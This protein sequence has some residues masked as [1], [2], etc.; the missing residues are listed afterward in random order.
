MWSEVDGAI[1]TSHRLHQGVPPLQVKENIYD[2]PS[3]CTCWNRWMGTCCHPSKMRSSSVSQSHHSTKLERHLHSH[4]MSLMQ[5]AISTLKSRF[6][7]KPWFTT[8][9]VISLSFASLTSDEVRPL[10]W[11]HADTTAVRSL[12][13]MYATPLRLFTEIRQRKRNSGQKRNVRETW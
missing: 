8:W 7:L 10:L 5:C 12:F 9:L 6:W 1:G 2:Q 11:W 3:G 4:Q 13:A